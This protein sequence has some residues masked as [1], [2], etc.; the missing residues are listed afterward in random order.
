MLERPYPGQLW[1]SDNTRVMVVGVNPTTVTYEP[2]SGGPSVTASLGSF[3]ALS[4]RH[5]PQG[6]VLGGAIKP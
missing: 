3:L 2:L 1:K 4:R 5:K 6:L